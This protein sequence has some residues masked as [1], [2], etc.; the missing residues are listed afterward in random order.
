MAR[1]ETRTLLS[2]D[3]FAKIMGMHPLH[4]NGIYVDGLA[5]VVT[6]GQPLMQYSWQADNAVAREDIAQAIAEAE[7]RI[8]QYT[9]FSLAPQFAVD[10]RHSW[11]RAYMPEMYSSW[12]FNAAGRRAAFKLD[13][14]HV[15]AGGVEAR[16]PVAVGATVT[17]QDL[18]GDSFPETAVISVPTT[19]TDANEIAL[20]YPGDAGDPAWEIRPI[21]V[22][23]TSTPGIATIFAKREQFVNPGLLESYS[24]T[25]G[26]D[27]TVSQNFLTTVDVYRVWH[28][29]SQ[30]IQFLW[31][32][33][34]GMCGCAA[35]TCRTCTLQAQFGCSVVTD[36][37]TGLMTASGAAWNAATNQY[38]TASLAI[39][40]APDRCRVWYRHGFR[41]Q[42]LRR[43]FVEMRGA[44]ARAVAYLAVANLARPLCDCQNVTAQVSYWQDDMARTVVTQA[45]SENFQLDRKVLNNPFGTSRGALYAWRVFQHETIG[46]AALV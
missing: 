37:R 39:G 44:W 29:P 27:G 26:I 41:D 43:P 38:E 9:R 16:T 30:Q 6:C 8:A 20:V 24:A 19:V 10:E 46:E 3:E 36:Y 25:R 40:R 15:I 35:D 28:D 31:D 13:W 22:D 23:L 5:S 1:A 2:L 32:N 45:Q 33:S 18:D 4:F 34:P 21:R 14:G 12:L 7:A 42:R 17:Y 11:P